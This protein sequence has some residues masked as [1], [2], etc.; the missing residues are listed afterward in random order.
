[1][2]KILF[3]FLIIILAIGFFVPNFSLAQT[4]SSTTQ[5]GKIEYV[6]FHLET[7][8][9]CKD[10]IKFI[11]KEIMPKY[12][13]FIDL[14]MYEVSIQENQKIFEQ[15]GY[16]YKV[17]TKGVPMAFIDGQVVN[18]YLNDKTTGKQ[19]L[20]IVEAK[21]Q[22]K[23]LIVPIE[24]SAPTC[25]LSD[26]S[27]IQVPVL[28]R[29]DP[30]TFSL[31][32]LTVVIGLLDGFNPCAMWVLLFLIS[33]LLGMEDKKRMWLL[34]SIFIVAS[35]LVYFV[36]M[37]AWLQ[38]LMF[39][40]MILF[41]RIGIGIVAVIVGGKNL[42]DYWDN[43]KSDGVVCK[44]SNQEGTKKTFEKIKDIVY[45]KSLWWS[46]IGILI[47]GFSVNLVEL[48][49][50]AGFPAVYTQVLA[51]SGLPMWERY[52]YMAGYIIFYMLDDM[53]VF[54]LAM[55]TLKSKVIGTKYAKY[56][57]LVGGALIFILG[58]LLIFKPEWL[59]FT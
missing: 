33:L 20:A 31:P 36:F 9:H 37:A 10:E 6:L 4:A 2:K 8:P 46:I 26:S 55:M 21:L 38:F 28:G 44:V 16:F 17:N 24:T 15:Y 3:S 59:M 47:L 58:L 52:L 41:V 48:A 13:E 54:V 19:I 45:R 50:S 57:N 32:I 49:C 18:G 51:L 25:D 34:G 12:G 30:K 1:M 22:G 53:V 39:I 7:C 14:K 42:K 23:G 40:G 5:T 56:A 29:I 11:N 43:R 27:C 35:G